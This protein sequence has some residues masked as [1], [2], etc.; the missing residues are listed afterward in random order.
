MTEEH[1][2]TIARGHDVQEDDASSN[3]FCMSDSSQDDPCGSHC[4]NDNTIGD[5]IVADETQIAS[6]N[7]LSE[8]EEPPR[9]R[10][11]LELPD[12]VESESVSEVLTK[13]GAVTDSQVSLPEEC[14]TGDMKKIGLG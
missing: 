11:H 8:D 1:S 5:D 10:V 6:S 2:I 3:P 4:S 12:L 9:K 14:G 13:S 7:E